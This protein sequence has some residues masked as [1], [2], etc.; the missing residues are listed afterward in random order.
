MYINLNF[1]VQVKGY[2]YFIANIEKHN[3]FWRDLS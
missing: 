1:F 3:N 2:F